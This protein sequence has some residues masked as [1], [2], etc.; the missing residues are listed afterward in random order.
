MIYDVFISQMTDG[1]VIINTARGA[2]IDEA[3]L[4]RALNSGKLYAAGLDVLE[5]EPPE[6]NPL[7]SHPR[8]FVTPH[9]A[10]T[11]KETRQKVIDTAAGNLD[12][13]LKNKDTNRLV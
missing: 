6:S 12:S 10:W 9:I 1:S 13:Y 8:C 5:K 11:P 7:I 2:L 4:L 3:A